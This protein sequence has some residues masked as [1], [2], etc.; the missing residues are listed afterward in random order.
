MMELLTPGQGDLIQASC[1]WRREMAHIIEGARPAT[2]LEELLDN[3]EL[4]DAQF[5]KFLS[6]IGIADEETQTQIKNEILNENRSEEIRR[7]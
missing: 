1:K 2:N 7:N 4:F 3:A 6:A 5:N